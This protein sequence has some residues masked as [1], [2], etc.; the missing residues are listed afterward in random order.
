MSITKTKT[1]NKPR[2]RGELRQLADMYDGILRVRI[3]AENRL[4]AQYQGCDETVHAEAVASNRVLQNLYEA[5]DIIYN[6][7]MDA[8]EKNPCYE[9]IMGIPGISTSIA[10]HVLGFIDDPRNFP[11]FSNLRTFAGLTPGK[12][13]L[14]KGKKACYNKR[15]KSYGYVAMGCMLKAAKVAK[16]EDRPECFY[17]DIYYNWRNIY[18]E[19]YGK[20][21]DAQCKKKKDGVDYQGNK[22]NR[23]DEEAKNWSD[24]HQHLA[25]KNKLLDVFL[26][27]IYEHWL[28]KLGFEVPGLYVHDVLGHHMKYDAADFTSKPVA[29]RKMKRNTQLRNAT[30]RRMEVRELERYERLSEEDRDEE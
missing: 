20:G 15:L 12:N 13:K 11:R 19:R 21:N 8:F 7:M 18:A 9:F 17:A 30:I 5:E 28:T 2:R 4:R 1:E 14:V 22:Y 24:L 26:Y 10:T 25:A 29:E 16:E 3:A 27:H 23:P 6:D